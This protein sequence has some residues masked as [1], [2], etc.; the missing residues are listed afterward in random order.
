MVTMPNVVGQEA[1]GRFVSTSDS[2]KEAAAAVRACNN[3]VTLEVTEDGFIIKDYHTEE[4]V[5]VIKNKDHK[6]NRITMK[7]D[8]TIEIGDNQQ[9]DLLKKDAIEQLYHTSG[10]Y[11]CW[12]RNCTNKE[13]KLNPFKECNRCNSA[14]YCSRKCQVED[15]RAYHKNRCK[16]IT[17]ESNLQNLT[18]SGTPTQRIHQFNEKYSI[19]LAKMTMDAL[20]DGFDLPTDYHQF[21][22]HACVIWLE[23][24]VPPS[25]STTTNKK[26]QKGHGKQ[27]K[28]PK[29]RIVNVVAT[30]FDE[31]PARFHT[32]SINGVRNIEPPSA[33]QR[34]P[35]AYQIVAYRKGNIIETTARCFEHENVVTNLAP[36]K[37]QYPHKKEQRGLLLSRVDTFVNTI[38]AMT[39]GDAKELKKAS[40]PK[41]K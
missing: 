22:T 25:T 24:Y 18:I 37:L 29:F 12:N 13:T 31:L 8:G 28:H 20:L 40:K 39:L 19:M 17:S 10:V 3:E 5:Q 6:K 4:V 21:E 7:D 9:G 34:K 36:L 41:K 33:Q 11:E 26:K 2:F 16:P 14:R 32:C 23:D 15:W 1:L 38:N 30:R 35:V 27:K